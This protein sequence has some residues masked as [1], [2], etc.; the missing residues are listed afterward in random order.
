MTLAAGKEGRRQLWLLAAEGESH[1]DLI[2]EVA[3]RVRSL[4]LYRYGVP[5]ALASAVLP[6]VQVR[7]PFGR[8]GRLRAG[9]C[10]RVTRAPW[11]QTLKPIEAVLPGAA[12]LSPALLELALWVSEYYAC[13]PAQTLDAIVPALLR[14][15]RLCRVVY[16][17]R[18][19][20]ADDRPLSQKQ[21][22]LL[23]ALGGA[24]LRRDVLLKAAAVGPSVLSGLRR[25]GL[26]ELITRREPVCAPSA[27]EASA[28]A[29]GLTAGLGQQHGQTGEAGTQGQ[30]HASGTREREQSASG[31]GRA[32]DDFVLTAGQQSAL[33]AIARATD[34][35]GTFKVF[36][37][38]GVPGSGKT[39]VYVRAMRRVVAT[40]RQAIILVPEIALATQVV[41]R[42]A[43]RFERVA[44]LHS[45]L[46][47]SMRRRTLHAIAAGQVDVVIGTRTAVFAPCPRLG[48]IVVDEEQETSFKNLQAPFFHA[49]DVAIKRGQIEKIPVVLGSATPALETW[50][51]ARSLAHF[52]L[53]RLPERVPG[54]C[55]P[56]VSVVAARRREP[57]AAA[58]LLSPELAR[59][60][61]ETLAAGQQSILLHNRRGYAVYV[62]CVR[63]GLTVGCER[64][65][66]HLVYHRADDRLKCHRCGRWTPVPEQCLDDS[67]RGRLQR[68]G[69][70]IQRLEQE[71]QR[72]FPNARVQRLD[73]DTMRR[74]EDYAA[75][76]ERF[77]SHAADILLGT[78]MVAKGLDFPHVR[79]VGVVEADAAL[80]LPDFRAAEWAFQLLVQVVG[81]AGRKEGDS[82][83]LVQAES[84]ELPP[85]RAAVAL[86]Y[87]AFAR[88]ELAIRRRFFDPPFSRLLRFICMD[89]RG[90]RA[91]Q[92]VGEL[93]TGL[94]AV[95]GRVHAGIR[96]DD[97]APC[98]VPR[99]R[100]LHRYH[101][102]VRV[103]RAT[104]MRRLLHLAADE[105]LLSP[106]VKRFV[107]DVDPLNML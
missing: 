59:R 19:G 27:S 83:A 107:I 106:K 57:G 72:R 12:P 101:V 62:R 103:P 74:R 98:V 94:R 2:A 92:A 20:G 56:A 33:D 55:L 76:L 11:E 49:R 7:V 3:V 104:D 64:C 71:L 24:E 26:I 1:S 22:A 90:S 45:R 63:C 34:A 8:A 21:R 97:P 89:P 47:A 41:E 50:T 43:R 46:K 15:A 29:G 42:L 95:A 85:I 84:P 61:A 96:V 99:L 70:G 73:S 17:R 58:D 28:D 93:A 14:R 87:E 32:E 91:S 100:E 36:L 48:L 79:L 39:E 54:A 82:L 13:P 23:A 78:Q 4:K 16:V 60:L 102:L 35:P 67:C 75:A 86:D 6:G 88:E 5:Q 9:W 38:F 105:K 40:G 31:P 65:G 68:T 44:V 77:A 18:T 81:R 69:L 37:L 66:T 53:L 52:E 80:R 30:Q 51:N 25:R 10:V